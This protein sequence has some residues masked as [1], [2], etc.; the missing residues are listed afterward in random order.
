[1]L[2]PDDQQVLDELGLV[3]EVGQDGAFITVTIHGFP[4]PA[5]LDPRNA[6]LLL[7]LPPGFPD[8]GPD[9]FWLRPSVTGPSGVPIPGTGSLE[10]YLGSTW[11]RW[12]RHIAGQWRPGIDNLGTYMAYVRRCFD[13]AAGRAA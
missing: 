11:Q 10:L 9:M 2:R 1:M 8:A 3:F 7:R 5:S 4:M 6:D 13:Q 12:S